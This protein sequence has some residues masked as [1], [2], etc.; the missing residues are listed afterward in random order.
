MLSFK[1]SEGWFNCRAVAIITDRD[2]ILVHRDERYDFWA[3]PGGRPEFG[4]SA[5]EALAREMHEELGIKTEVGRLVWI[6]EN[7]FT[8]EGVSFHEI[9][10]YF[11]VS[12]PDDSPLNTCNEPFT[13]KD[14]GVP[15]I[16]DWHP[17]EELE[18]IALHPSFL[19][20]ALAHMPHDTQY[21]V[22]RDEG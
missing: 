3:L 15:L 17:I 19:R 20:K 6:A 8:F 14:E 1:H 10:F 5:R 13:R 12:L 16:F 7:F 21:I 2:R 11:Q 22:H 9:S 4:E 18:G